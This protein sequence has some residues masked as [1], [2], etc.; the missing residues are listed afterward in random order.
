MAELEASAAVDV[1]DAESVAAAAADG[2][3]VDLVPCERV[4]AAVRMSVVEASR[5][6]S[7]VTGGLGLGGGGLGGGGV[8]AV[9]GDSV[10]DE[11]LW[12]TRISAD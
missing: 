5:C 10:G 1:V 12:R 2:V 9:V 4:T 3:D 7:A 8:G 6:P 11:V